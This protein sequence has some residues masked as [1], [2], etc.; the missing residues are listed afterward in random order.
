MFRILTLIWG[1]YA[2]IDGIATLTANGA[3]IGKNWTP[4]PV[5]ENVWVDVTV[6]ANTWTDVPVNSNVW[7]GVTVNANTWTDVPVN[8]NNWLRKG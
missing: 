6:N 4:I 3:P 1:G 8:S 7:T 2:D 5:D